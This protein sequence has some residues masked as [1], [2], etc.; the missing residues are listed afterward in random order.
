MAKYDVYLVDMW[1]EPE[2][3]YT[4][5]ERWLM[6][7]INPVDDTDEEILAALKYVTTTDITGRTSPIPWG[8]DPYLDEYAMGTLEV[9][10]GDS[11]C[12]SYILEEVWN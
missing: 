5:N 1:V 10:F 4:E 6:G 12:P 3:S 8:E 7:T 11:D 9:Y 2:G